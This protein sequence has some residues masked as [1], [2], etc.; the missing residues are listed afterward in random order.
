MREFYLNRE[1]DFL[2]KHQQEDAYYTITEYE[3]GLRTVFLEGWQRTFHFPYIVFIRSPKLL[4]VGFRIEPLNKKDLLNQE[5]TRISYI[6]GN[7][8]DFRVCLGWGTANTIDNFWST[9]FTSIKPA[10]LENYTDVYHHVTSRMERSKIKAI[11]RL[12][13]RK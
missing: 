5:L 9:M 11:I 6:F 3:P 8:F 1:G 10:I 2:K 4:K 7:I 12:R 13:K